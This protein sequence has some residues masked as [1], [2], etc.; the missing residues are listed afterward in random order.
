M[1]ALEGARRMQVA[2]RRIVWVALGLTVLFWGLLMLFSYLHGGSFGGFGFL[3]PAILFVYMA[4][5]GVVLWLA[6]W[7]VEGFAKK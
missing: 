1:N 2:G 4:C 6:G 5:P 7:I 3:E